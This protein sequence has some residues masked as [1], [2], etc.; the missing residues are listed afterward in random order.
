M[1]SKKQKSKENVTIIQAK[2]NNTNEIANQPLADLKNPIKKMPLDVN[3]EELMDEA[4][5]KMSNLAEEAKKIWN[6]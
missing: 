5:I 3:S 6:K 2:K 4:K 1:R